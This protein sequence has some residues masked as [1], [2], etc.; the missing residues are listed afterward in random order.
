MCVCIITR[1]LIILFSAV[2]I[3]NLGSNEFGAIANEGHITSDSKEQYNHS[4]PAVSTSC[5]KHYQKFDKVISKT[6]KDE[7]HFQEENCAKGFIQKFN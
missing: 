6:G 7:K 5:G 3:T 2:R 4:C 1:H